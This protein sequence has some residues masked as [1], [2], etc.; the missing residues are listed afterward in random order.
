MI[1]P[2]GLNEGGHVS[3]NPSKGLKEKSYDEISGGNYFGH[4]EKEK[5]EKSFSSLDKKHSDLTK[6]RWRRINHLLYFTF[7]C[8]FILFFKYIYE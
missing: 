1:E 4:F 6:L 2:S 7:G 8:V 3:R 5:I